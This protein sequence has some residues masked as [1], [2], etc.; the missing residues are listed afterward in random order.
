MGRFVFHTREHLAVI[1]PYGNLLILEQLRF[2]SEIRD[3]AEL[4][5]PEKAEA[6]QKEVAMAIKLI[7]QLTSHFKPKSYHDN[8]TEELKKIIE[9]KA[10]GRKHTAKKG[11]GA[12]ITPVRD[13]MHLLKESLETHQR[14]K[15][16]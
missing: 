12:T 8:Y 7:D 2:D 11:K 10:K 9:D 1:R 16:A 3:A 15:A 13:I 6:S 14:K 5:I 4:K